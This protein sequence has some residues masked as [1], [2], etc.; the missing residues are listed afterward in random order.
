MKDVQQRSFSIDARF[1]EADQHV[2]PV[3]AQM[4]PQADGFSLLIRND[5]SRAGARGSAVAERGCNF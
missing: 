3:S 2:I 1:G 5:Y 4:F